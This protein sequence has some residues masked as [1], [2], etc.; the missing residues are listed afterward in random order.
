VERGEAEAIYE[1]GEDVVVVVLL[2][3]DEQIGRLGRRV[4]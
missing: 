1:R 4:A 3:M 2:G